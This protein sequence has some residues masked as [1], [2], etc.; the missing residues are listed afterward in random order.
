VQNAEDALR[1]QQS[2][3]CKGRESRKRVGRRRSRRREVLHSGFAD[4][5]PAFAHRTHP[6]IP[7]KYYYQRCEV[8][9]FLKLFQQI[10][11]DQFS[12]LQKICWAIASAS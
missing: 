10:V 12:L 9:Q 5:I 7:A 11:R 8:I 1:Q 3:G 2:I 6:R 4:G